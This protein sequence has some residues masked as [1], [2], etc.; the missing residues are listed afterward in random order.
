MLRPAHLLLLLSAVVASCAGNA[1]RPADPRAA[2]ALGR[3]SVAVYEDYAEPLVVDWTPD[4]RGDLEVMMDQGLVVVRMDEKGLRLLKECTVEG[5]YGFVGTQRKEQVLHLES[6]DDVRANLPTTGIALASS[7]S[8]ELSRGASLDIALVMVGRVTSTRRHLPKGTL[9]AACAEA[10]HFVRAA[11]VGAFAMQTATRGSLR[12][13]AQLLGAGVSAS[14]GSAKSVSTR[15]GD[16]AACE[17]TT[18]GSA[19]PQCRA[20]LRLQL[21]AIGVEAADEI[22]NPCPTGL[23]L[24]EG[25]CVHPGDKAHLCEPKDSADCDRQCALGDVKSCWFAAAK[26]PLAS[27]RMQL[28]KACSGGVPESCGRLAGLLLETSDAESQKAG[29]EAA[30]KGCSGGDADG[31]W[32]AFV[33]YTEGA[34]VRPDRAK[35]GSVA[36]LACEAGS[37]RSCGA[38]GALALDDR[39]PTAFGLTS[40]ACDGAVAYACV[41]K[42]E[43]Y[44]YGLGVKRDPERARRDLQALCAAKDG[45]ACNQLGDLLGAGLLGKQDAVAAFAAHSSACELSDQGGCRAVAEA[46]VFGEGTARDV[47]RGTKM[48]EEACEKGEGTACAQLGSSV[49]KAHDGLSG[50]TKKGIAL[51]RKSCSLHSAVGC[52]LLADKLRIGSSVERDEAKARELYQD[53]CELQS[54]RACG[55][56]GDMMIAGAGGSREAE[57]G[58]RL[59]AK[60]CAE[61]EPSACVT[62]AKAL[63]EAKGVAK[64]VL[65][66]RSLLERACDKHFAAACWELGGLLKLGDATIKASKKEAQRA[67]RLAC[68]AG[69]TRGCGQIKV[70]RDAA[71][72]EQ[73]CARG[74][75]EACATAGALL[76]AE[77]EPARIARGLSLLA[78][79]CDKG[80][81]LACGELGTAKFRGTGAAKDIGAAGALWAKGCDLGDASSCVSAGAAALR[82]EIENRDATKDFVRACD[83]G[84]PDG[85]RRAAAGFLGVAGRDLVEARRLAKRSCD[86]DWASGCEVLAAAQWAS[87]D[88]NAAFSA[89]AK[90]CDLNAWNCEYIGALRLQDKGRAPDVEGALSALRRGCDAG[91]SASCARLGSVYLYGV[92][93]AGKDEKKGIS[94]LREKCDDGM[95]EPCVELSGAYYEGRGVTKDRQEAFRLRDRGCKAGNAPACTSVGQ[96]LASGRDVP[97]DLPRAVQLWE[98]DCSRGAAEACENLAWRYFNGSDEIPQDL[99]RAVELFRRVCDTNKS[100]VGVGA[101]HLLGQVLPRD[102]ARAADA[103]KR[104]CDAKWETGCLCFAVMLDSGRGVPKDESSARATF[105]KTEASARDQLRE[106]CEDRDALSCT[107]YG[108]LL[109]RT[110][111]DESTWKKTLQRACSLGDQGSC[112]K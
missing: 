4:Q 68:D 22:G 25:V 112:S 48:W 74:D 51:I 108:V 95:V 102:D 8:G 107:A 62:Q 93:S 23:S 2:E 30:I 99:K 111:G 10:T 83:A 56:L 44:V 26:K 15:D 17:Q 41:L 43:T 85:C 104:A 40:R 65:L 87:D 98:K 7:L 54:P 82:G 86:A 16:L 24:T 50:D 14:S 21:V 35:A 63:R 92:A 33:A 27:A 64:N 80:S 32:H 72:A 49:L 94:L 29:F 12:T 18:R 88:V 52:R 89:G 81:G 37:A 97:K 45:S 31:C 39:S 46:L 79:S 42:A 28:D 103:F 67:Y 5:A 3:A 78:A 75:R 13:A 105:E 38:L 1:T 20:P 59:V 57:R 101:A 60:A 36:R 106:E 109:R 70:A 53:A 69:D 110:G 55:A 6:V 66:A 76:S 73:R 84:S 11:T 96:M 90:A 19:V 91:R 34:G 9:V 71:D 77:T 58:Y 61:D 100:C 47:L